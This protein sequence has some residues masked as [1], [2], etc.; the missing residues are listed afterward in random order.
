[1][2]CGITESDTKDGVEYEDCWSLLVE[3]GDI[4][5]SLRL[6]LYREH[7]IGVRQSMAKRAGST[8]EILF[9]RERESGFRWCS[10]EDYLVYTLF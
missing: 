4:E 6:L 1:V 3:A 5:K 8:K 7:M 2:L 9:Q 10:E